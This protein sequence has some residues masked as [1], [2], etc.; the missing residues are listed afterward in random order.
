MI[1][2]VKLQCSEDLLESI[3]HARTDQHAHAH[4]HRQQ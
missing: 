3:G 1:N 4:S 2:L